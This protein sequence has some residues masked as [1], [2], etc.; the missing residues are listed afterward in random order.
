MYFKRQ[1]VRTATALIAS[2]MIVVLL[3]GVCTA[4]SGMVLLSFIAWVPIF[5]FADVAV[6][7]APSIPFDGPSLSRSP[8]GLLPQFQLPPPALA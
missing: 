1:L 6:C 7:Q 4:H 8:A 2:V 3:V 5:L